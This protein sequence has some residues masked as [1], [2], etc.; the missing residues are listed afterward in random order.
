MKRN[1]E[2]LNSKSL[3][4]LKRILEEFKTFT[5]LS[6]GNSG[7]SIGANLAL[8][9]YL[10][11]KGKKVETIANKNQKFNFLKDFEKLND[12]PAKFKTEVLFV[13]SLSQKKQFDLDLKLFKSKVIISIDCNNTDEIM[14]DLGFMIPKYSSSSQLLYIMLNYIEGVKAGEKNVL[15]K[16]ILEP[17]IVGLLSETKCLSTSTVDE[18]SFKLIADAIEQGV[19]YLKIAK[20][21][22]SKSFEKIKLEYRTLNRVMFFEDGKVAFSILNYGIPEYKNRNR[23]DEEDIVD[24]MASIEGVYFAILLEQNLEEDSYK[25]TIASSNLKLK[26]KFKKLNVS[27]IT[28][29]KCSL[30]CEK[31]KGPQEIYEWIIPLIRKEIK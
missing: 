26:K 15:E 8:S 21:V 5:V 30:I 27:W 2:I 1:I 18:I 16:D 14:V 7:D 13:I 17:L 29:F 31:G 11:K 3:Y 12:A 22:N 28:E 9:L 4:L 25:M 23:G 6:Y 19:D 20:I 24:I 10:N